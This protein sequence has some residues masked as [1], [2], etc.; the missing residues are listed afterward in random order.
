MPDTITNTDLLEAA[1]LRVASAQ[2]AVTAVADNVLP[3]EDLTVIIAR[4]RNARASLAAAEQALEALTPI[5]L[6]EPTLW[7]KAVAF[8]TAP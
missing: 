6:V 7:S 8:F 1:R 2:K 5:P 4:M 3:F